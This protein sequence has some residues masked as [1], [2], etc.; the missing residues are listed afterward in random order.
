MLR[1]LRIGLRIGNPG[2]SARIFS[3]PHG[4]I[5]LITDTVMY[6]GSRILIRLATY[7]PASIRSLG[8]DFTVW[9]APFFS[10]PI[11]SRVLSESAQHG[12]PLFTDDR[13]SDKGR[14]SRSFLLRISVVLAFHCEKIFQQE[15]ITL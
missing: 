15:Q 2:K 4:L 6:G 5:F 1:R 12:T 8:F 10:L 9:S 7:Q 11:L 13:L 14:K 3:A